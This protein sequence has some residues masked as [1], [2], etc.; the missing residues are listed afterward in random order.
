M[1]PKLSTLKPV[2]LVASV[3]AFGASF[4]FAAVSRV[5]QE[6]Y[7]SNYENKALFLKSPVFS[8]KQYVYIAGQTFR[9]DLA[10]AGTPRFKVGDQIRVLSIDFGGEEIKFKLGAIAGTGMV[11]LVFRFDS[12]LQEN[13]PNSGV[14]DSAL[15]ATF[16]E[17]LRYTELEDAQRVFVEEEFERAARALAVTSGTDREAVLKYVA[18]R[19]PAY[20][21]AMRDI[22]NLQNKN[23]DLG[24]QIAQAQTE[25]RKLEAESRNQQTEIGRLRSQAAALQEKIDSS[26]TQL[27]R[28][29]D[30][31]RSAK[32]ASQ[33]SQ[34]ELANLQR[35]LKI[36]LDS[37][38]DLAT[39]ISELGLVM[40]RIQK[41]NGDLLGERGSL[42]SNLERQQADNARLSG[43]NQDLRNSVQ[44]MKATIATLTS[45]E[46]SLAR[47]YILLKQERDHLENVSLSVANLNTRLAEVKTEAGIQSGRIHAFLGNVLLGTFEWRLPESLNADQEQSGEAS[48]SMES[49]DYVRVTPAERQLLQSLGDRMK[50]RV[51]LVPR[52]D[53][54]EVTPAKEGWLQEIGERDRAAWNWSIRNRGSQ[55]G[56]L[57]LEA[58]LVN[59]NGDEIPLIQ[60][61]PLI[62]SSNLVRQVRSY[63]LPIPL[64]LGVVLGS[65]LMG[66]VGLF[67]RARHAAPGKAGS[68][69]EPDYSGRKQL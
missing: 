15:A 11:E 2:L 33:N 30:D 24:R 25:N 43:E 1:K 29:G 57:L 47:Q 58:R 56:R 3:L 67:M 36:K 48:F 28:L 64:L 19:L 34:R 13:F 60:T 6:R 31:V 35:S 69:R 12:P 10:L 18:P 55:D 41:E 40:Q 17:G 22:E 62:A 51:N 49:I 39:Q 38:R 14:F 65:L 68:M 4:T 16:T 23:Q 45:K 61:E 46:D 21:D 26:S 5:I 66:I 54:L 27:Q 63:L 9:H 20:Q 52:T 44:Q 7:R 37:S 42:R 8:E 53:T 59:K 50:L 32:G